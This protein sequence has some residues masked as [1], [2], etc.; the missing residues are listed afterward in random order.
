MAIIVVLVTS[1]VSIW[2]SYRSFYEISSITEDDLQKLTMNS[3]TMEQ[4]ADNRAVSFSLLFKKSIVPIIILTAIIIVLAIGFARKITKPLNVLSVMI[5]RGEGVQKTMTWYYEADLLKKS[6]QN[7]IV[8]SDSKIKD[9]TNQLNLDALTGIPNRR[10]MDQALNDL[11]LNKVPHTI[12]L[13]DLDDF[14]SIND[15]Y[16][17]MVGDEVLKD[18]AHRMQECIKN[19]GMCFRYGGEEFMIIL[20]TKTIDDAVALAENLRIKQALQETV[21]GKPV[22]MSAGI[23]AFAPNI[24]SP[25]QLIEIADHA[26]YQAKHSGRNCVCVVKNMRQ[27][28][29]K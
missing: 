22:T 2:S 9:L 24:Q 27:M 13:I 12:I 23:T 7:M 4:I 19:Q 10:Q 3:S 18:F 1:S 14:K 16:G 25:N 15:T 20:P 8:C 17:H 26:L 21:C 6:V 5:E 28:I 29:I 11:I